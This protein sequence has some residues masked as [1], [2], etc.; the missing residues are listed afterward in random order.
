[1]NHWCI[2]RLEKASYE[3]T[4]L[5]GPKFPGPARLD[6]LPGIGKGSL[7][8]HLCQQSVNSQC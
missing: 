1:M 5:H 3:A 2:R 4:G 8:A 7:D 6:P